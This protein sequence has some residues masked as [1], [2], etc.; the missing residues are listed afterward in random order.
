MFPSVVHSVS[1]A[2]TKSQQLLHRLTADFPREKFEYQASAGVN[3]LSWILGHLILVDRRQLTW[4]G[5]EDLPTLPDWFCEDHYNTTRTTATVQQNLGDPEGLL[6]LFHEHRDRL[7]AALPHVEPA[8]YA[9]PPTFSSPMFNNRGEATL[10]MALH[11]SM[12]VGQ[13][14]LIR[15]SLGLPP[16]S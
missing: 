13:I 6:A 5:L 8:R 4:L 10:F 7:I 14:S 11:T 3:C 9:E 1:Y 15:R 16:I 12:H 2:L